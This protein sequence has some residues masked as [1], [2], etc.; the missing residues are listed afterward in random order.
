M[1]TRSPF[2]KGRESE[3]KEKERE[4]KTREVGNERYKGMKECRKDGMQESR[5]EGMPK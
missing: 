2:Q 4:R 1:K 5:N 3:G